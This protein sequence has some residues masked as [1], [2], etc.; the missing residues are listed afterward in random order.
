M[1]GVV[2]LEVAGSLLGLSDLFERAYKFL[3]DAKETRELREELRRALRSSLE[4]YSESI[5]ASLK[6]GKALRVQVS[7]PKASI[8][9]EDLGDLLESLVKFSKDFEGVL[10]AVLDF[11]KQCRILVLDFPD[12]MRRV[13]TK[14]RK[15]YAILSFF[16]NH[17]DPKT[18]SLDLTT[19]PM[20]F[21]LY[22][23][24]VKKK[25]SEKLSKDMAE[26]KKMV[27]IAIQ[28]AMLINRLRLRTKKKY[29]VK[30]FQV[31]VE[32]M[33]ETIAK[34]KTTEDIDSQLSGNSPP[35]MGELAEIIDDVRTAMPSLMRH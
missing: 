28:N 1:V 34:L 27:G 23:A 7:T 15:V 35:W 31:S 2:A 29:L 20:L 14:D 12:V 17:F 25:E 24:K 13:E 6:S 8:S 32:K 21:R 33:L 19:I 22:G 3:K 26:H 10:S 5:E 16:G 4:R 30:Q 11:S 18:K 9:G